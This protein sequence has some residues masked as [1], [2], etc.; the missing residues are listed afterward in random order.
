MAYYYHHLLFAVA[1][2]LALL[3]ASDRQA[4]RHV[5][6]EFSVC[7]VAKLEAHYCREPAIVPSSAPS[8]VLARAPPA[9]DY[10]APTNSLEVTGTS[11][12]TTTASARDTGSR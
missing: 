1:G 11:A 9:T 8:V 6:A 4:A 7:A 2:A 10:A 12:V 3:T 5:D